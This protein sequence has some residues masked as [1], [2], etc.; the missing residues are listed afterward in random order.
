MKDVAGLT[1]LVIDDG[2]QVELA[3]RLARDVAKVYYYSFW[4]DP[5]P[6]MNRGLVGYGLE[7]IERVDSPF[8]YA[9]DQA[10]LVVFPGI[11]TGDLQSY[12]QQ[13]GKP[14]FGAGLGEILEVSRDGTKQLMKELQLPVNKWWKVV[15]VPALRK[16]LKSH[17]DVYVKVNKYR[18]T[19]E[20]F[21]SK[22]YELSEPKIDEAEYRLGAL[23]NLIE[24]V[25][26]EKLD[27]C[28]EVGC[29]FYSA[30]GKFPNSFL[31]GAEIKDKSYLG[32]FKNRDKFPPYMTQ[33]NDAIAPTLQML[34]YQGLLSTE[35]RVGKDKKPYM[36]D[37][38]C[39][40]ASPPG[41]LY[42]EFYNNFT[43][44][45]WNC[46]NGIVIE[47]QPLGKY[48][49]EVRICSSWAATNCQPIMFPKEYREL[50]KL[51]NAVCVDGKY[52]TIP[53]GYEMSEIG[54]VIGW[55]DTWQEATEMVK[56]VAKS[57][58]GVG[59][60]IKT[61]SF[62]QVDEEIEKA[63]KMGLAWL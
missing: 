23:K 46:A 38:C 24:F 7:G 20:S 62:N 26:E 31:A 34:G 17:K 36:I 33:F 12:L 48:G 37:L 58:E 60:E 27:D 49:A 1:V 25:V 55:G 30:G 29:D 52:Y 56:E 15:G 53:Q 28:I 63:E 42:Q 35:L 9:L 54:A 11:Y 10:D 2:P 4:E 13:Q 6:T 18:G 40:Q 22:N 45:V 32:V 43:D 8:G 51:C 5:F 47:P 61:D 59:I 41:E 14:C 44:I 50:I 21:Y 39:R 57:I 3:C 19:F 16:F